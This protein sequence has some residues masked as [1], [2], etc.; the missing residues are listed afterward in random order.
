MPTENGIYYFLST[1]E[2]N[3]Y[4]PIVLIHGAGGSHLSWGA[5]L[6][7]LP[8]RDIYAIDL[9]GHGKSAGHGEQALAAYAGKIEA[10]M[11][12]I[13]L[14]RAV[15][16]GHSMGGGIALELALRSPHRTA[17]LILVSSGA[18][19]PVRPDL[20]EHSA[21]PATFPNV[22]EIL[23]DLAFSPA[24]DA[25]LADLAIRRLGEIRPSVLHNDYLACAA[26][27][28]SAELDRIR[29]PAIVVYGADDRLIPLRHSQLLANRIEGATL[30]FVLGAGH[31]VT[32]EKPGEVAEIAGDFVR[33][34]RSRL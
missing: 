14:P 26:F 34:H 30:R 10:W 16:A 24:A 2:G 7:R 23:R 15:F 22:L 9:P 13:R 6:R 31:M 18:T 28:V 19:L 8:G 4:P 3:P 5:E 11:D 17:G 33:K 21:G 12:R 25:R 1:R 20:L 29:V 32:L 27:D